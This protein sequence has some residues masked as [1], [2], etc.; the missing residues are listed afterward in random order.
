MTIPPEDELL[1]IVL[2][3]VPV[4]YMQLQH[5]VCFKI[6]LCTSGF[7]PKLCIWRVVHCSE[8]AN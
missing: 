6:L 8:T 2:N 5:S 4:L 3:I 7:N 1:F